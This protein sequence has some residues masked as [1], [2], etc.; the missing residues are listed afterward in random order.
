MNS[1]NQP[2]LYGRF[3]SS[4]SGWFIVC[5]YGGFWTGI[6]EDPVTGSAHSV[7]VPYWAERLGR[8]AFSAWQASERGGR[9]S[10]RLDGDR[11]VLGG[12]CVTVIEGSFLLP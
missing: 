12:R 10:C 6:P 2:F 7:I 1:N 3:R 4:H 5:G 9:L 8:D 11:V